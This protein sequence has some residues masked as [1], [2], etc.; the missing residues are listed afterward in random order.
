[1]DRKYLKQVGLYILTSLLSVALILYIGYH[2][3]YGLTQ[4]VETTPATPTSVETVVEAEM[5][6][7]RTETLLY[8]DKS[9]GS[10]VPAVA[11][12]TKVAIDSVVAGRYDGSSPETVAAIREADAQLRVLS[13]L[14]NNTLS[15]KDTATLEN[16]IHNIVKKL[17]SAATRGDAATALSYRAELRAA[18]SRRQ[19]LTDAS[20]DISAEIQEV[21]AE[22]AALTKALGQMQESVRTPMSGYY[23]GDVDGYE[24]TFTAATAESMTLSEFRTLMGTRPETLPSHVAGKIVTDYRWYAACILHRTQVEHLTPGEAY[25][26]TFPYN[27]DTTLTMTLTRMEFE[28]DEVLLLFSGDI[29]PTDF[30]YSRVQPAVITDKAY[31]GL[32][33]PSS[34]LRVVDG[35]TGVYILKGS[36]VHFR[37][38]ELLIEGEDWCLVENEP[39][40]EAPEGYTHLLQNDIVITKGRGLTEGRVLS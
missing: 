13:A 3:F 1:M 29:M 28:G 4:K 20:A 19:I 15:V 12:G 24:G 8:S 16:A 18:I 25:P 6:L 36:V 11:D 35:V 40:V 32:K 2:M 34:A 30:V 27:G 10:V 38:V 31:E 39:Q 17:S 26:F 7:F 22:K 37:A 14:A 23:Y 33:I 5:F 9:G 21:Q